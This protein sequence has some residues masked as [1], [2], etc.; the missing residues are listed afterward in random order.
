MSRRRYPG[1][2]M[3][4]VA[5]GRR[6]IGQF[7]WTSLLNPAKLGYDLGKETG[8]QV[9]EGL[10]AQ[11]TPMTTTQIQTGTGQTQEIA[12]VNATGLR[13]RSTAEIRSDNIIGTLDYGELV[14]PLG[15][16]SGIFEAVKRGGDKGGLSGWV[17]S[18]SLDGTKQYLIGQDDALDPPD[19]DSSD[20]Y[21]E[22][23][24]DEGKKSGGGILKTIVALALLWGLAPAARYRTALPVG[25]GLLAWKHRSM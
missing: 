18:Q 20:S 25:G 5:L 24:P 11:L 16:T 12:K 8:T 22:L 10:Q 1:I 4:A 21:I 14:L 7:D 17:A 23:D 15:K 19:T 2:T 3:G 13:M 9:Q 6:G